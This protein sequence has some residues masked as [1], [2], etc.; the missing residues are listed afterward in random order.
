MDTLKIKNGPSKWVLMLATFDS[1]PQ[2]PRKVEFE[3]DS[4]V[5]MYAEAVIRGVDPVGI[6]DFVL[7][8]EVLGLSLRH[9]KS[10]GVMERLQNSAAVNY[11]LPRLYQAR[12][13]TCSRKGVMLPVQE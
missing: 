12:F 2:N 13:S 11:G 9:K 1:D 4:K 5:F 6:D 8:L 7:R 3:F 10:L